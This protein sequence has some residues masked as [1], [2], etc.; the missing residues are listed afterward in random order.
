MT[1]RRAALGAALEILNE[2][3]R[4]IFTARFL[5]EP[6]VT[7]EELSERYRVSRER[8]RQLGQRAFE[9]VQEHMGV[10]RTKPPL[11]PT[12]VPRAKRELSQ[13]KRNIAAR[14]TMRRLYHERKK[15]A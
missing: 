15:A 7:L 12:R 3:E 5:T 1:T 13:T 6:A 11:K 4:E 8:C 14:D 2:R 9:K 10:P